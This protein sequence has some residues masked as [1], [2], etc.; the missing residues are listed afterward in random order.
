[1]FKKY[2]LI[3]ALIPM[4]AWG[5]SDQGARVIYPPYGEQKVVFEFFFDHPEKLASALFWLRAL[6]RTLDADP[7]DYPP[8]DLKIKVVIHGAE[9]VTLAK[10]NYEKYSESVE[11]MRYY[12]ELG[13]E[14]KICALA[15]EEF[16]YKPEEL[17]DFV[18]I[19]PSAIT[20]IAHW[21]LQGYA[22]IVPKIWD[23]EYTVE[24]I[25]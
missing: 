8:D 21:Q 7:Y 16:N 18:D 20:E 23:K 3:L 24:E 12:S 13:V 22:L 11:R 9:I 19:V 5:D 4:F 17:Q 1:M 6:M 14:F 25:R 2:V 10:K 15:A